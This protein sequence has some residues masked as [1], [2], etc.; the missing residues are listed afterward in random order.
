MSYNAMRCNANATRRGTTRERNAQEDTGGRGMP[1]RS[2]A[3]E[4]GAKSLRSVEANTRKRM[5][6]GGKRSLSSGPDTLISAEAY[7]K[8]IVDV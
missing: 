1:C 2:A 7:A 3:K 8:A 6:R 4:S 5:N